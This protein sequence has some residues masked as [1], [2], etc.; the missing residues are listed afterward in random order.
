[1]KRSTRHAVEGVAI[2][3]GV[4]AAATGAA[5]GTILAALLKAAF[6]APAPVDDG[7]D[8]LLATP[9]ASPEILAVRS[10]DGNP[11]HVEAYGPPD[12]DPMVFAHGW[13]CSTRHWYAQINA[14][15]ADHRVIV[16]D[17]RGHGRTPL[18]T[19]KL[20]TSLLGAD[21]H[22]V[23]Q[24]ATA[25]GRRALVAGHSMGGMSVMAWAKDH[26]DDVDDLARGVV[27]TSTAAVEIIQNLAVI[28][29]GLP[30]YTKPF[31]RGVSRLIATAPVPLPHT[32][33]TPRVA[34]YI[35]MNTQ[36]RLA[37]VEFCDHMISECPA[38][39]RGGWGV[40]MLDLDVWQGVVNLTVPTDV[41]VGTDDRLTPRKHSDAIVAQLEKQGV[42]REYLV[43]PHIGHMANIED[44]GSYNRLLTDLLD[45]TKDRVTRL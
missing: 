39:A 42:L 45:A 22:A 25:G 40:A 19:T 4:A 28:P 35:A 41:V 2:G 33:M 17:Q 36:A 37:H 3:G 26:G 29:E 7:P 38:R 5:V 15:S 9:T 6:D 23:L 20:S 32:A 21:L 30:R 44:S 34:Q 16:Y 1:M 43:L 8:P 10:A 27:L 12:A 18:G 13:T 31:E 11:I 14:F 24:A